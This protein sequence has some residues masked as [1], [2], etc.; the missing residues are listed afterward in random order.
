[1]KSQKRTPYFLLLS[2]LVASG[3]SILTTAKAADSSSG[4]SQEVHQL[5][6]QVKTVAIALEQDSAELAG[7]TRQKTLTWQS[8]AAKLAEIK[9]HV[10]K[11]GALLTQ[12]NQ[13]REGASPW[14]HQAIDRIYPIL[15]ELDDNTEATIDHLNDNSANIHFAAY[16]DYAE[17][18]YDLSK[19]LT[20]LVSDYVDY[21]EHEEAL[22]SLQDKLQPAGS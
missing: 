5:L 7:W 14:Q 6:S 12:L 11:A 16:Q 2:L 13:A 15:K 20:T 10:N 21:G 3:I 18:G 1:M 22:R 4:S 8:H 19:E 17:A 9:E